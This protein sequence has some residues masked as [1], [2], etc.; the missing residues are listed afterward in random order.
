M[1]AY[2]LQY[3]PPVSFG[4]GKAIRQEMLNIESYTNPKN[5]VELQFNQHV[6]IVVEEI[7]CT[8]YI[9]SVKH[10]YS[11]FTSNRDLDVISYLEE[12]IP[13]GDKVTDAAVKSFKHFCNGR[14]KFRDVTVSSLT[15]YR[16]YLLKSC[17]TGKKRRYS[18]NTASSYLKH[19]KRLLSI[20][21][22]DKLIDFDPHDAVPGITWDHTIR[23]ERLTDS[24]IESIR[25]TEFKDKTIKQAVLFSVFTGLRR[26]DVLN[27]QWENIE[28]DEIRYYMSITIKKT[29]NK[30]RLP[31]TS[32]VGTM[33][34]RGSR[35]FL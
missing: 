7:R 18:N 26:S 17:R 35:T 1:T 12:N 13:Y 21:H 14:F 6:E 10:D 2:S 29:Q 4:K 28:Y 15:A 20:A 34:F 19:I 8:R 31:L 22:S 9:Q 33:K 16:D 24:E 25:N 3:N 30:V 11:L 27:L 32:E 5:E 23:K